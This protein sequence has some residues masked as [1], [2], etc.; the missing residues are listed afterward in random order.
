MSVQTTLE[1]LIKQTRETYDAGLTNVH[2]KRDVV[3]QH[4][5]NLEN[6]LDQLNKKG[7]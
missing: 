4:L 5:V 3:F 2:I 6:Q 7:N 1:I